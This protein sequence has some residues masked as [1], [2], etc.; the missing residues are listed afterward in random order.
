MRLL[1][2]DD[3][4]VLREGLKLLLDGTEGLRVVAEAADGEEALRKAEAVRPD[5][6]LLDVAMPNV[7]GL[8]A[9]R[10]I[11]ERVPE[12]RSYG[13]RAPPPAASSVVG[14]T[15]RVS[16]RA[17]PESVAVSPVSGELAFAS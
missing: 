9:A 13:R 16:S 4:A 7:N 8:E 10:R 14:A 1:I 15:E 2:V 17:V 11:K 3:H 6:I 12:A 5:L